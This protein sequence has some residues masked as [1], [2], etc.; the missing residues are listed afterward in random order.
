MARRIVEED[1]APLVW[2]LEAGPAGGN[3]VPGCTVKLNGGR[4]G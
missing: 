2:V 4:V 1:E 3:L